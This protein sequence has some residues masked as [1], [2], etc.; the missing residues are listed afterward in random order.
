MNRLY[1]IQAEG[2]FNKARNKA[3]FN[4]IQNFLNPDKGRLLSFHDVKKVLKPKNEV[5]IGMKTVPITKIAGS[6]G[7]YQDFDNHF[8]PKTRNLRQRWESVDEAH[9]T[10]IVLP[11]IQLYEI[12]GLYFVR[13]GNH[14]VSVAKA[15]GI[16][17]IDAEVISLQSEIML[18]PGTTP[19]TLLSEVIKYEKRVLYSE[20][21]FGDLTDEWNLDFTSPGQYDVIYNHILVHKYYINANISTEIPFNDALLSWYKNVYL[22]VMHVIKKYRLL[23]K[24]KRRTASDLYVWIIKQWD[25]LKRKYGVTYTLDETTKNLARDARTSFFRRLLGKL[26]KD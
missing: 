13:D 19:E 23:R 5:Y 14:R 20:T 3:I 4:E 16:D 7:R 6:E 17:F 25:E 12:G 18:K 1:K 24:F 2:D 8:L 10:D 15:Q 9:L 11:P 21:S 26:K 22:P